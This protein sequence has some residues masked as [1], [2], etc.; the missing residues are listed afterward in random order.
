MNHCKEKSTSSDENINKDSFCWRLH[1]S[2]TLQM[3]SMF[4]NGCYV[5]NGVSDHRSHGKTLIL[6]SFQ[7]SPVSSLS[8]VASII[9]IRN[10]LTR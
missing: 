2:G 1:E 9:V 6:S 10:R 8:P 4:E 5:P 7:H 3:R